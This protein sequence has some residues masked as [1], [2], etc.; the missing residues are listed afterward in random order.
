MGSLSSK[1]RWFDKALT[2][3][4]KN[5]VPAATFLHS[6]DS[7]RQELAFRTRSCRKLRPIATDSWFT[8]QC[9]VRLTNEDRRDCI[10]DFFLFQPPLSSKRALSFHHSISVRTLCSRYLACPINLRFPWMFLEYS[11]ESMDY[12]FRVGSRYVKESR[13]IIVGYN[14]CKPLRRISFKDQASSIKMF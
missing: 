11:V 10:T 3:L 12:D 14:V 9:I 4:S 2:F 7:C 5:Q 6:R 8:T 13:Y 1:F